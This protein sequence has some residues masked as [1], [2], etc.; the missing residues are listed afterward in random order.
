LHYIGLKIT[1]L[2]PD[3]YQE[4]LFYTL[5]DE[6]VLMD[7]KTENEEE[8]WRALLEGWIKHSFRKGRLKSPW[9]EPIRERREILLGEIED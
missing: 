9:A 2:R 5:N 6:Q 7:Y 1:I 8:A 4:S 3:T